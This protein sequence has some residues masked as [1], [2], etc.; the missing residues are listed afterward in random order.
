MLL[1]DDGPGTF[2]YFLTVGARVPDLLA[3]SRVPLIG[4]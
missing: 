2:Y 1:E 4:H 3:L